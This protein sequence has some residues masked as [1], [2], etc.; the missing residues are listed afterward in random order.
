MALEQAGNGMFIRFGHHTTLWRV[1]PR[2]QQ[3]QTYR[4][5][6][7]QALEVFQIQAPG[8]AQ[9]QFDNAQPRSLQHPQ[10]HP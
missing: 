8:L 4:L 9:R 3:D 10:H 1:D 5:L 6:V 7:Q 2:T